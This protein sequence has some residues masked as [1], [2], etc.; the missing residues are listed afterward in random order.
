MEYKADLTQQVYNEMIR[1]GAVD[2][3]RIYKGEQVSYF[4]SVYEEMKKGTKTPQQ[5]KDT[6]AG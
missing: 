5:A 2:T 1:V 4:K 6:L 3:K